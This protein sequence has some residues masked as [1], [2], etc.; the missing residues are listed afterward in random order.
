MTSILKA[1]TIQDAAGNN[2]INENADTITIGAA[3]D[4]VTVPGTEVK[5][6]KLSPASGTALQIGDSGDTITIPSGATLSNL[7]TASGFGG[8]TVASQFRL[9][10]DFAT[11]GAYI[12]SNWE[13]SDTAPQA[14]LG[15][16]T[17][18]S[19][20]FSLPSTGFYKVEF[21]AMF[22]GNGDGD[23]RKAYAEIYATTDDTNYNAMALGS[24]GLNNHGLDYDFSSHAS[25]ILDMTNTSNYKL[26]FYVSNSVGTGIVT[27]GSTSNSLTYVNIIR[28]G[29][30]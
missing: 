19:G 27:R 22:R 24:N 4:T 20:V 15:S 13:A 16:V 7:G 23:V 25:C 12:T 26:K 5:S 2:I 28:L 1:D 14:N 6:N 18:S 3:G 8:I 10:S 17:E 30:T 29:D 9:T 11:G 21:S